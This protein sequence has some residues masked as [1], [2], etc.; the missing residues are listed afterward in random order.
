VT[1]TNPSYAN[2]SI[3]SDLS[4]F[5][6]Y[7]E[8]SAKNIIGLYSNSWHKKHPEAQLQSIAESLTNYLIR[9]SIFK[10]AP[11]SLRKLIY[12]NGEWLTASNS[13]NM[14]KLPKPMMDNYIALD[15]LPEITGIENDAGNTFTVLVNELTHEPAFLEEPDYGIPASYGNLPAIKQHARPKHYHANIAALLLLEKWFNYLKENE[16]YENT[17]IVIVSDH[18]NNL[19][20][21]YRNNIVLPNGEYVQAFNPLL[22]FKDF[23][24]TGA[25]AIDDSFMSNADTPLLSLDGII[26]NPV[27]PF[28]LKPLQAEKENGITLT[29]TNNPI[30]PFAKTNNI[31]QKEWLHVHD[32]IFDPENWSFA[33][34]EE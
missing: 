8:I 18:G 30:R 10:C 25:I 17:R 29:I 22:M 5:G 15:M 26:E 3:S 33:S 4:I 19:Q 11:V 27:N 20:S 2:Y 31:G 21:N 28:T 1:I 14:E 7:P 34:P 9:F 13:R 16:V 6:K 23:N 32:N 12:D 24:K